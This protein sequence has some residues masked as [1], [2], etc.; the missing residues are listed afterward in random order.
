MFMNGGEKPPHCF[1]H[2]PRSGRSTWT[3]P[4]RS[5]CQRFGFPVPR[6]PARSPRLRRTQHA[7]ILRVEG[8]QCVFQRVAKSDNS[9]LQ[10]AAEQGDKGVALLGNFWLSHGAGTARMICEVL[11]HSL[12]EPVRAVHL[13]TS[14][15]QCTPVHPT[16]KRAPG[17]A[18]MEMNVHTRRFCQNARK[19]FPIW[20]Q[21]FS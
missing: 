8:T 21:N 13:E 16:E 15:V 20:H 11:L 14:F 19:L 2:R 7:Q 3:P 17:N 9:V 10:I 12:N 6:P 18:R 1:E 4:G 5:G